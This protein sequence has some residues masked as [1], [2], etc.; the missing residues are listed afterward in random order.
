MN[1]EWKGEAFMKRRFLALLCCV[2]TVLLVGGTA[3]ALN[4][5]IPSM[6]SVLVQHRAF[7]TDTGDSY[8][9]YIVVFYDGT[10]TLRQLNDETHFFKSAGYTLADL[11]SLDI[12]SYYPGF[13]G[14]S[15]ADSSVTDE[16]D[17]FSVVVRFSKLEEPAN[18]RQMADNGILIM[19][20]QGEVFDAGSIAD[21]LI[22]GGAQELSILD[23]ADARL[24]FEVK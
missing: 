13:Y 20:S 8:K 6:D 9:E 10:N 15:F 3:H 19:Q 12:S 24:N 21:S 14:M 22:A 16:G 7:L 4:I 23:Y 18:V 5:E 2:L 17:F 1:D 11:Q